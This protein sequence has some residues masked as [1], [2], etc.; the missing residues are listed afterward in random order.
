MRGRAPSLIVSLL[1]G[2]C[3]ATSALGGSALLKAPVEKECARYGLQ[4]CPELVEG[5]VLYLDGDEEVAAQQLK[6]A[7]SKNVPAD[8]KR[9]AGAISAVLPAKTGGPIV[10]ILT[11]QEA[12]AKPGTRAG[13]DRVASAETVDERLASLGGPLSTLPS[14]ERLQ[15]SIAAQSDPRRMTTESVTPLRAA[16]K[17]LCEIGGSKAVC[18]RLESGPL[19]VTDAMTPS[20]CKEELIIGATNADGR[21]S[22][23]VP[24]NAPGFHGARFFVRPSQWVVVAARSETLDDPGDEQCYVTW[25]AFKPRAWL[26]DM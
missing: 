13:A 3:A 14:A 23:L 2:G 20:A 6:R 7:A 22:W 21:V 15:L 8:V 19:V 26:P 9:F 1:L 17:A 25:A 4:G 24:T 16:D 5:V 18:V 12:P 11:G 10:A